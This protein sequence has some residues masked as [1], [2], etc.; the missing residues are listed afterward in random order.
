MWELYDALIEAIP[1]DITVA[2]VVVG[3]ESSYV[4]NSAGGFGYAGY[5]NYYQRVPMVSGNRIGTSLK[6]AA[7]CIKSWNFVEASIGQAAL[8]SYYN[9]PDVA[10]A[11][12]V[13]IPKEKRLEERLKDPFISS[14]NKVKGKKV[15]IVGHFPFLEGLIAPVCDMSIIEWDP[16][17]G[18]YPYSA[19]EYLL[20]EAD[21][22][23]LTCAGF[24]DKTLPRMLELSENAEEVTIVGP[25]TPLA[26]QIFDF[27]VDD[28]S[29]FVVTDNA[30]AARIT[31]G[32]ENQRI[33]A[34]GRK[35]A[36][37][38]T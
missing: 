26:P 13:E 6:D 32:A 36:F 4:I 5:R 30:L 3:N 8:C 24:G 17:E 9:H 7:E 33:F 21:Y 15:V 2:E 31:A 16:Q 20:P 27:G 35:V 11:N 14:Q 38:R 29:G 12:G 10:A 23:F 25:A 1:D 34:S 18:D 28:L 37:K 22:A 19:I